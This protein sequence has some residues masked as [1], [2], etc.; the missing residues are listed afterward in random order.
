MS[1][2][3]A[4]LRALL[5]R[6]CTFRVN[7]DPTAEQYA[8]GRDRA[9]DNLDAAD[10]ASSLLKAGPFDAHPRH[11]IALDIDYPV[12]V[13]ESSTPGHHHLYID[14][15]GGVPHEGYMALV[16]LLAHLGVIESGY[17]EV[18]R[19]RGHTDLRLPWVKKGS[20]PGRLTPSKVTTEAAAGV[21]F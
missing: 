1:D 8:L 3:S 10:V 14:V 9:E 6:L 12:H 4:A 17:A 13:V 7:W 5:S 16:S 21:V 11:I 18:S 20:E 15:P 19:Q 2:V